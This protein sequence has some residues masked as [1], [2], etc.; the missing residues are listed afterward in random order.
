MI[1]IAQ[2]KL[3]IFK[4]AYICIW[5]EKSIRTEIPFECLK[6]GV[7]I[8]ALKLFGNKK[9]YFSQMFLKIHPWGPVQANGSL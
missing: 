6:P 9:T 4:A 2:L 7:C 3:T 8:F 1:L 5:L